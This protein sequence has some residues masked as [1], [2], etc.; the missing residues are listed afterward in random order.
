MTNKNMSKY[1]NSEYYNFWEELKP[2]YD[3]FEK[4]KVVPKIKV[5]NKKYVIE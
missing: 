4:K 3:N 1:S 2:A 5:I